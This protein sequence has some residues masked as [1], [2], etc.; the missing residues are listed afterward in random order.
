MSESFRPRGRWAALVA[1]LGLA[2]GLLVAAAAT[3]AAAAPTPF[4]CDTSTV[5]LAQDFPTQLKSQLA[6]SGSDAF[7]PVGPNSGIT[8]NAIGYNTADNFIYGISGTDLIK[9]DSTGAVTTLAPMGFVANN[10]TFGQNGVFYA[11][12]SLQKVLRA[13]NVTTFAVTN[14]PLSANL[15]VADFVS[16]DNQLWG[17]SGRSSQSMTR[18]DPSTGTVVSFPA[19]FLPASLNSGATWIYG[20]GDLGISDNNT[21]VIY[22]VKIT[23][24][25]SGAPGITLVSTVAGPASANNDATSCEGP[26][27]DLA[28]SKTATSPVLPGETITWTIT[29]TNNGPGVSTGY[30][31]TDTLPAGVTGLA[32]STPG[33]G[34]VGVTLTCTGGVLPIGDSDVITVTGV[35]P[36]TPGTMIHNSA[37]VVGVED[38]PNPANNTASADTWI[39]TL[40]SLCRGTGIELLNNRL[41]SANNPEAPCLT[42]T[43]TLVTVHETIGPALPPP[44]TNAIDATAVSGAT[45]AG[46]NSASAEAHIAFATVAVPS[47]VTGLVVTGVHTTASSSIGATCAS[48]VTAGTSIIA[49]LVLNGI[50]IPV[51]TA[52]ISIPLPGLGGLYLNQTTVVGNTIT[53]KA[54]FLDLPGTTLDVTLAESKA[55]IGCTTGP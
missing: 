24:P 33:C 15:S 52:P 13:V 32:T 11:A 26:P 18:I 30:T 2:T 4:S 6:T 12:M 7:N 46:S 40:T 39:A 47:F 27:A 36:N 38:E 10:G 23:N 34:I 29:V 9:I 50:A 25:T 1:A 8:Y 44:L 49:S 43:N 22:R 45:L 41:A 51:G 20:N 35:A 3:P 37:S 16:I 53:V 48:G 31:V 42:A 54:L 5:F 17:P 28:L 19:P 55:G 21:G 14:I